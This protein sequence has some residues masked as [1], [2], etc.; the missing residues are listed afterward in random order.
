MR[1][2][3]AVLGWLVMAALPAL[4]A[5]AAMA[6]EGFGLAGHFTQG[7]LVSGRAEP[8]S[9]ITLDG[10]PIR[11]DAEG[12]FLFGF[13]RE[14]AATAILEIVSPDGRIDRRELVITPRSFDI[15][16]IDGLPEAMVTPDPATL[17]RIR[18]ENEMIA[19]VRAR[20][21]DEGGVW[22]ALA[23]GFLRP[24]EGP[25]S[26]VYGSQ[27]ILNGE[28]RQPHYGLDIAGPRGSPVRAPAAGVVA[29]AEPDLYY[30]GATILI[31]HGHG[32]SSVLMHLDSIAVKPGDRV[33]AG[34]VVG[35]LGAS[36]RA[37]GP[38]LDW[39]VNWFEVRLDPALLLAAPAK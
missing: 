26:G 19:A 34:D 18:R 38:H 28:P 39:R 13:G 23:G 21:S 17:E 35:T 29:L 30:T 32:L 20:D 4:S 27:R 37:T 3:L 24:A 5:M 15:Q 6:A 1:G 22:A 31:D 16:R 9:R 14:A 2:V 7:G 36:G 10:R 25:V 11:Q 33:A 12:R 8:G